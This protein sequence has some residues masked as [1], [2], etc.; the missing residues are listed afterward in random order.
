MCIGVDM[1]SHCELMRFRL[2]CSDIAVNS[3]RFVAR[4]NRLARADRVCPCCSS[5]QAEDELH[6]IFECTA[7]DII[8]SQTRF[9]GLFSNGNVIDMKTLFCHPQHQSLLACPGLLCQTE[10]AYRRV[11]INTSCFGQFVV[12]FS[13]LSLLLTF[14]NVA[15]WRIMAITRYTTCKS[16]S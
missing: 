3:G 5:G 4:Q 15:E 9:V 1:P 13:V 12:N 14:I 11:L 6:V 10:A 8:R 2:G 16:G 7:Y